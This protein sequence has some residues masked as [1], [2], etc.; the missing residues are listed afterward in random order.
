MVRTFLLQVILIILLAF[1]AN[2]SRINP[3]DEVFASTV[4]TLNSTTTALDNGETFTGTGELSEHPDVMVTCRTDQDGL[5]YIDFSHD[6]INWDSTLTKTLTA[7]SSEFMTAVKGKRYVRLRV[8]N[9]SGS[10]Q[11]YLRCQT[12]FGQFRQGN[13]PFSIATDREVERNLY[14]GEQFSEK[15]DFI[16]QATSITNANGIIDVAY[17][18]HLVKN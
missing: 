16:F 7:N 2:A 5:L 14:G 13:L 4:S 1:N 17:A 11:T 6:K 8:N 10:N 15:T 3:L 18:I 9:N 12:E